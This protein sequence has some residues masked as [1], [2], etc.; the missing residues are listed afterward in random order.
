MYVPYVCIGMYGCMD[1]WMYGCLDGC[2]SNA[3]GALVRGILRA[4]A[5]PS[6]PPA[7][8]HCVDRPRAQEQAAESGG[9]P[10]DGRPDMEWTVGYG[11]G[12][13]VCVSL[14]LSVCVSVCVQAMYVGRRHYDMSGR[15][16]T[17]RAVPLKKWTGAARVDGSACDNTR[18]S[19]CQLVV[20]SPWADACALP[21]LK[22]VVVLPREGTVVT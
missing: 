14:S 22:A 15:I 18:L 16:P 9:G 13:W 17:T 5:H 19:D 1:V 3:L 7:C 21:N 2:A 10:M 11:V 12:V 20:T 4:P 8:Q 6:S